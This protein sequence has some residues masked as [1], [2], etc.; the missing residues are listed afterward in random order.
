MG[1]IQRQSIQSTFIIAF[2]FVIGAFNLIILVPKV[3]T[4]KEFGLTRIITE[5]GMTLAA[6]CTLG[7]IPVINKFFPFYKS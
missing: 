1:I 6:L 5:A 3:L 2:G 4:A 7:C